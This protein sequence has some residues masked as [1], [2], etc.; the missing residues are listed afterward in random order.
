M[1]NTELISHHPSEEF[2][3]DQRKCHMSDHLL[4][5]FSLVSMLAE[6]CVHLQEGL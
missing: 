6:Q 3:Q 2:R 1:R 4:E 5:S